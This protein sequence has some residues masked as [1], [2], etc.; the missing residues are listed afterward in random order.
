[1]LAGEFQRRVVPAAARTDQQARQAFEAEGLLLPADAPPQ[2]QFLAEVENV[3]KVVGPRHKTGPKDAEF[4]N[5]KSHG[6]LRFQADIAD[7]LRR[8]RQ[9]DDRFFV[10]RLQLD[11]G[12]HRLVGYLRFF[13]AIV[14]QQFKTPQEI[15]MEWEIRGGKIGMRVAGEKLDPLDAE[16][17]AE[18]EIHDD[19][20]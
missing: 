15:G 2:R 1:M 13:A 12:Q 8:D 19:P 3:G 20:K 4:G 18:I 16:P 7:V 10:F 5:L 9:F 11:R 6:G 17:R 14:E